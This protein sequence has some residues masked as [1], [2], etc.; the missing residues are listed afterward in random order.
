M[1]VA[2]VLTAI[3]GCAVPCRAAGLVNEAPNV[4]ATPGS[5]GW[6]DVPLVNSHPAGDARLDVAADS[7]GLSLVGPLSVTLT[8]VSNNTIAAPDT[9]VRSRTTVRGGAAVAGHV[10]EPAVHEFRPRVRLAG[11]PDRELGRGVRPG[12]RLRGDQLDV[13]KWKDTIAS[14]SPITSLSD[15]NGNANPVSPVSGWIATILEPSALTEAAPTALID[16][17]P[18]RWHRR[19]QRATAQ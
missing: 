14:V 18:F 15:P 17:E 2:L 1:T 19:G 10:S 12:P 5:S 9:D 3:P 16:L 13:P 11:L 8:D 4:N 6:F 7:L